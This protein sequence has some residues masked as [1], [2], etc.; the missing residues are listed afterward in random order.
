MK[1]RKEL[2]AAL[3]AA[4]EKMAQLKAKSGMTDKQWAEFETK[5]ALFRRQK[6]LGIKA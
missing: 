3:K 2:E 4:N 5:M 6:K 1:T